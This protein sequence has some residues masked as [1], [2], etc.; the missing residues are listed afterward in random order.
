LD[1]LRLDRKRVPE[2]A[3]AHQVPVIQFPGQDP[4]RGLKRKDTGIEIVGHEIGSCAVTC[5]R[6]GPGSDE[7]RC[8]TAWA[9]ITGKTGAGSPTKL[10]MVLGMP[11]LFLIFR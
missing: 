5:A 9:P 1:E 8:R 4:E 10:A 6:H 2:L 7:E 3:K 11:L